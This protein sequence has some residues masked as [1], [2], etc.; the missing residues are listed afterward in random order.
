MSDSLTTFLVVILLIVWILDTLGVLEIFSALLELVSAV[1]AAILLLAAWAVRRI[2]AP[3]SSRPRTHLPGVDLLESAM[4]RQPKRQDISGR[5][6]LITV[7]ASS[8]DCIAI[9]SPATRS[10]SSPYAMPAPLRWIASGLTKAC[11]NLCFP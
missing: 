4:P 10:A 2:A 3:R 9:H 5:L 1:A 6:V 7:L 11:L 8:F